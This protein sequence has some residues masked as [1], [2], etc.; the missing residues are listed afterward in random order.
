MLRLWDFATGK[1]L[2]ESRKFKWV[3]LGSLH[4]ENLHDIHINAK[5]LKVDEIPLKKIF[6][7]N[8]IQIEHLVAEISEEYFGESLLMLNVRL[9][10][11]I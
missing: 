2:L 9:V 8:H 5:V 1:S 11:C 3:G 10:F 7:C 4:S 6:E